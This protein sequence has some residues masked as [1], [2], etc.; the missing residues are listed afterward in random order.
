MIKNK[1]KIRPV[2]YEKMKNLKKTK[3]KINIYN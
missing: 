2:K 3:F 1:V